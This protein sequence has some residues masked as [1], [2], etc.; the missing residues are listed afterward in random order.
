MQGTDQNSESG[1]LPKA[2]F[3]DNR[4]DQ[5]SA[6]LAR[7][8]VRETLDEL[9]G[10]AF[11]DNIVRQCAMIRSNASRGVWHAVR[12]AVKKHGNHTASV[13]RSDWKPHVR[14]EAE[15][16]ERDRRE[17][18]IEAR[19]DDSF[20]FYDSA[21]SDTEMANELLEHLESDGAP[22]VYDMGVLYQ[23]DPDSG[24]WERLYESK[25]YEGPLSRKVS[26]LLEGAPVI[27]SETYEQ[28]REVKIN[29]G[30]TDGAI[31]KITDFRQD[32]DRFPQ[33][34]FDDAPRGVGFANTFVEVDLE[35]GELNTKPHAA[36]HAQRVG[37]DFPLADDPDTELFDKEYLKGVFAPDDDASDKKKL[38]YE[39]IGV[40][41]LGFATADITGRAFMLHGGRGTG[42]STLLRIMQ[43]LFPDD[44]IEHLQPQL[45]GD[46]QDGAALEGA[47]LNVVTET[48]AADVLR[49]SGFK[50]IVHGETI[51]R[52]AKYKPRVKFTPRAMH[53]FACNELPGAPGTTDAYWDRWHGLTFNRRFRDTDEEHPNLAQEI[54]NNEL[55]GIASKAVSAARGVLKRGGY[56]WPDSS[57]E[58][59]DEWRET[60]DP[61]QKFFAECTTMEGVDKGNKSTWAK[62]SKVWEM[63]QWWREHK[64]YHEINHQNFQKRAKQAGYPKGKSNTM[65][66]RCRLTQD[67]LDRF[68]QAQ[69]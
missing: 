18:Q 43:S 5:E 41:I 64:G 1:G 65:R 39:I 66:L 6:K 60:G 55:Q 19:P 33:P 42:K 8:W 9:D 34:F 67:T 15:S 16:Y 23:Y 46:Q 14:D 61:V 62:K 2:I 28:K 59:I 22:C 21:P 48:P 51:S 52:S 24:I 3:G 30:D 68:E 58:L 25:R 27:D 54:I 45:F 40:G 32:T 11:L 47:R 26:D 12:D 50:A 56:T 20:V 10:N 29:K 63:W 57:R 13:H 37:F 35:A 31:K 49:E 36:E 69:V 44:A 53:L 17:E 4:S 38:V 7:Q